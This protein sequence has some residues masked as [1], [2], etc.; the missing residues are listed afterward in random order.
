MNIVK[1]NQELFEEMIDIQTIEQ[2]RKAIRPNTLKEQI[3]EE[4]RMKSESKKI[5]SSK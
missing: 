1:N 3:E 2:I 4:E 5:L